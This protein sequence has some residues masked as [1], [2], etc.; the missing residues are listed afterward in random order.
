M[1]QG[2]SHAEKPDRDRKNSLA[3]I[4]PAELRVPTR[5]PDLKE[6]Y[7]KTLER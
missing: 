5:S 2:A 7:E 3:S 1:A 4:A 6:A